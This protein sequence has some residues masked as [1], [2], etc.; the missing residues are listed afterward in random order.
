MP[1][2]WR[3]SCRTHSEPL[4]K[5]LH[6]KL[7]RFFAAQ[8]RF[9]DEWKVLALRSCVIC[10]CTLHLRYPT[11]KSSQIYRSGERGGQETSPKREITCWGGGNCSTANT[12]CCTFQCSMA[13][14]TELS[15]GSRPTSSTPPL[16]STSHLKK[17][18]FP[19]LHSVC[20]RVVIMLPL[21]NY[22]FSN[23]HKRIQDL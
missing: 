2:R 12:R 10:S 11:K 17:K 5:V 20:T 4:L 18:A 19:L 22:V 23:Q 13:T 14:E 1:I 16:P 21:I 9:L 7:Q 15:A 3:P 8:L 6:C